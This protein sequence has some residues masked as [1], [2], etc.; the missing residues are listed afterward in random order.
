MQTRKTDYF[1]VSSFA[2]MA[3]EIGREREL[4]LSC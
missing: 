3:N 2:V 4:L 1:G